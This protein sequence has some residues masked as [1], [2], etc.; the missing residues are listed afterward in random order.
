[1]SIFL[2]NLSKRPMSD[3]FL[4]PRCA[5]GAFVNDYCRVFIKDVFSAKMGKKHGKNARYTPLFF[6]LGKVYIYC[7]VKERIIV[8]IFSRGVFL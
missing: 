4:Y 1:M 6:L 8:N 2:R 5:Q 3:L 7:T